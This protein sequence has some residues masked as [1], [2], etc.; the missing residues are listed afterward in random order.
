MFGDYFLKYKESHW[1]LVI[2]NSLAKAVLTL[3]NTYSF[4]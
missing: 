2:F 1:V 3:Q 4:K